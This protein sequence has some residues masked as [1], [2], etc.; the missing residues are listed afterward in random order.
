VLAEWVVDEDYP[1]VVDSV[2]RR[3]AGAA[4]CVPV[5]RLADEIGLGRRHLGQLVRAELGLT[6]K[7]VARIM[8]FGQARR[9]LRSV[10]TASLAQTAVQCGYFD[11]AHLTNDWKRLADCT[12]GEWMS[13]ELPFLQDQRSGRSAR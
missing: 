8:R 11:Q 4:G 3:L 12:P 1:A 13:E 5:T 9:W 2:W 7:T 10:P 6:P